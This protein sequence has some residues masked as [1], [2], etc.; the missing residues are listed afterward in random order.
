MSKNPLLSAYLALAAVCFFWGTTYLG[1]RMALES[2]PPFTLIALRY[3]LSGG[4]LLLVATA[5]KARL[6][7]GRQLWRTAIF[8]IMVLGLGSGALVFAEELIPRGLA[9]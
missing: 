4:L 5:L 2:F 1:I 3:L 6:P 9:A 8:G 7:K